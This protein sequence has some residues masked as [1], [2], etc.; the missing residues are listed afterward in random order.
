[1]CSSLLQQHYY[2]QDIIDILNITQ[3]SSVLVQAYWPCT[4]VSFLQLYSLRGGLYQNY[5]RSILCVYKWVLG[6]C[7][8]GKSIPLILTSIMESL[9]HILRNLFSGGSQRIIFDY[10][11]HNE[12][13]EHGQQ[14]ESP[15][16]L[17]TGRI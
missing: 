7:K 12:Q 2:M 6:L 3:S 11:E 14:A 5:I 8:V 10:K 16:Q 4:I 1:M 15:P 13:Q 17:S 9:V